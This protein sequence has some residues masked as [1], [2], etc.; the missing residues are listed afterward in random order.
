MKNKCLCILSLLSLLSFFANSQIPLDGLK[1]YFPFNNNA[2]DE[3]GYGFDGIVNNA[4]ISYDRFGN[5]NSAYEFK[6]INDF[7]RV[8]DTSLIKPEFPFSISLWIKVDSFSSVSSIIYASDETNGF[9]SGFWIGYTPSGEIAAG[10]GNGLGQGLENRVSKHSNYII[11]TVEWHNI[12][13]TFNGLFDIDLYID[14]LEDFGTYS[15]GASTMSYLESNGVIGRSLGHHPNS[16]HKGKV[17]DIRLYNRP[18]THEEMPFL[19]YE[20]PCHDYATIYDTILVYDTITMVDSI[21]V[22]D[23]LI[24]D[25]ALHVQSNE[26]TNRIKIYPNPTNDIVYI[27]TGEFNTMNEYTIRIVNSL[28]SLVFENLCIQQEFQINISTFGTIGL[29]YI[30]IYDDNNQLIDTRKII[31]E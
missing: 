20:V 31:L 7:I 13:A 4:T 25:I 1:L 12:I 10:Y 28:G 11:D 29:Y 19:C 15:G 16:N 26:I 18:L 5:S 22:T 2:L 23:T 3:S 14:C 9:Y 21:A 27:N 24:I 30:Q 6:S 8:P 17:D